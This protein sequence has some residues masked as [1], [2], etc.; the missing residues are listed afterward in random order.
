VLDYRITRSVSDGVYQA[1]DIVD[2]TATAAD[3]AAFLLDKLK[4]PELFGG[5]VDPDDV[6]IA[7]FT[8]P[9]DFTPPPNDDWTADDVKRELN[10]ESDEALA[11][12]TQY[13]GAPQGRMRFVE[14]PNVLARPVSAYRIWKSQDIEKYRQL[15]ARVW[16]NAVK[17]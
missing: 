4:R 14:G 6:K 16:P 13:L 8:P 17:R 12:V 15:V 11:I 3:H 2:V 10:L 5:P 9:M 7:N 1:G